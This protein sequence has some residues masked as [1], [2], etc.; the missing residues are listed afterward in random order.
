[1]LKQ[2][3]PSAKKLTLEF[4]ADLERFYHEKLVNPFIP[5]I[6]LVILFSME[7]F[8]LGHSWELKG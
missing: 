7:K 8:C 2:R 1:M 4:S 6:S 3:T 5:K